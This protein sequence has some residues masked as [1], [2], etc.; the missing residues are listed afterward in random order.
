MFE[1]FL[2]PP[3]TPLPYHPPHPLPLSSTPSIPAET[4]LP[5][6]F[7]FFLNRCEKENNLVL[8]LGLRK[9]QEV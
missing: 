3:L 4:I 7:F 2:P 6:L 8:L 9:E 1:S 5:F